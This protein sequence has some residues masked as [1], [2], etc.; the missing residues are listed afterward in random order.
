MAK[1]ALSF[2]LT[3]NK[4]TGEIRGTSKIFELGTNRCRKISKEIQKL[5][6]PDGT[7]YNDS[8]EKMLAP[9]TNIWSGMHELIDSIE[10]HID[11]TK[12]SRPFC[13]VPYQAGRRTRK[14][15]KKELDMQQKDVK[16]NLTISER[17][18]GARLCHRKSAVPPEDTPFVETTLF[19][20]PHKFALVDSGP[21]PVVAVNIHTV[22]IKHP[23]NLLE[24]F[25]FDVS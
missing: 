20:H 3:K 24:R 16:I 22:T 25:L 19:D 23:T 8:I 9:F 2:M 6:F 7:E 14:R 11:L 17:Y 13:S 15:K 5:L 18:L 4:T 1:E 10:H 21:F 12:N